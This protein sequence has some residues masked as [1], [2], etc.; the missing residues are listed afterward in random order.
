[1]NFILP[2]VL[3]I[4][5]SKRYNSDFMRIGSS[6]ANSKTLQIKSQQE[7]FKICKEA[8]VMIQELKRVTKDDNLH[9]IIPLMVRVIS[10]SNNNESKDEIDFKIEIVR[11]INSL[12]HCKSFREYIA[13]IVH[14]MINVMDVYQSR[15]TGDLHQEII[16]LF[17]KI[18]RVLN[19]DFAPFIPL[20]LK[21]FK[22]IGKTSVNF[23]QQIEDITKI[24][25]VDLFKKNLEKDGEGDNDEYLYDEVAGGPRSPYNLKNPT[26]GRNQV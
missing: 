25:L 21:Q 3:Q 14:T 4:I 5:E 8:F 10:R 22:R 11:T 23:N 18:S 9:L 12:V 15:E 16:N 6:S 19:I 17:C 7:D 24:N 20:I 1:M 13:T 26:Y 2:K